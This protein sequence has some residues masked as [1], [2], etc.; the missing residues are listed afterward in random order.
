[1]PNEVQYERM[2]P[3][4]I[5]AAREACPAAYLPLGTIE[6]HGLH[7]PVGLD[8]IKAHALAVRCAQAGGGLVFPPLFYGESREEG[9]MEAN[10]VDREQIAAAMKLPPENFA[11]GSMR[12]PP[13]QQYEN[14]QRLLLHCLAEVQSLGFKVA[15]LVTGHY[16]LLDHARAA[17]SV[18]HQSRWNNQRARMQ[19]WAFTGYEL[20]QEAFPG[21]GDHA[22]HWET[23]LLMALLP[24][25]ADLSELPPDKSAR[26]V[27]VLSARPVQESSAEYG[28]EAI[29]LLVERITA[30]VRDRLEHPEAYYNHGWR[31]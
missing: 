9:L 28:E 20:V 14:Y 16:P 30:Q 7:N 1:M 18:F 5:V 25:L 6:W 3:K 22:G 10:A 24:G 19:T 31:A 21:G 26:L 15:A 17:C 12:H 27:G 13:H 8:A 11:A 23:S 2:R 29:R 4:Q